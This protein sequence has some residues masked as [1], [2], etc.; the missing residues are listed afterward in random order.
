MNDP[1]ASEIHWLR[2]ASRK[3]RGIMQDDQL[4]HQ[5]KMERVR[6]YDLYARAVIQT[7]LCDTVVIVLALRLISYVVS[8]Q[9]RVASRV[10]FCA[11]STSRLLS[12]SDPAQVIN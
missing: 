8:A 1:I 3:L 10:N 12:N 5:S 9:M 7:L 11:A 4:W 2:V 6:C